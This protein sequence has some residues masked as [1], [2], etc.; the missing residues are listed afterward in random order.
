MKRMKKLCGICRQ[1]SA[2]IGMMAADQPGEWSS[3]PPGQAPQV[4]ES[5][6]NFVG[7]L[8]PLRVTLALGDLR[9]VEQADRCAEVK[10][11]LRLVD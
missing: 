5:I 10:S 7:D 3:T 8:N 2:R 4:R 11:R 1:P 9:I 6:K